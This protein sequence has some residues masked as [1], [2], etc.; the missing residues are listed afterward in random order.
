MEALRERTA[1]QTYDAGLAEQHN[2][3]IRERYRKLQNAEA[4]QFAE[5]TYNNQSAYPSVEET[6]VANEAAVSS[7]RSVASVF[8]AE[9]FETM[10]GFRQESAYAPTMVAPVATVKPVVAMEERYG[11]TPLAKVLMAVFTLVIVAMISLICV[12]TQIIQQKSIKIRNLEQKKEQLM[13]KNEEIQRRIQEAQSDETIM[14]YAESKGM[15]QLA[16]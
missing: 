8:T 15:V 12:N 3:M 2:A 9:K 14:Q 13:E 16:Q 11:L 7:A 10:Q 5:E 6:P 1:T 4:D